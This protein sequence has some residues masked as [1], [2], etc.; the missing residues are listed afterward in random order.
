MKEFS[1]EVVEKIDLYLTGKLDAVDQSG[2]ETLIA[3]DSNLKEEV[4]F[5]KDMIDSIKKKE[6]LR[7]KSNLN[8]I[9]VSLTSKFLQTKWL[10]SY[11]LAGAIAIGTYAGVEYYNNDDNPKLTA[12]N[13]ELNT[14]HVN[15]YSDG[16]TNTE[17]VE[18]NNSENVV[19]NESTDSETEVSSTKITIEDASPITIN[20]NDQEE[21]FDKGDVEVGSNPVVTNVTK[22]SN[23]DVKINTTRGKK[24]EYQ[25]YEDKLYLYGNFTT[26]DPYVIY[27]I[28]TNYGTEYYFKIAKKYYKLE[29]NQ[30]EKKELNPIENLELIKELDKK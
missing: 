17:P 30:V 2:F 14:N 18:V 28:P 25:F 9:E 1:Q 22:A 19:S 6:I 8:S 5:Q 12:S 16:E 15:Y 3:S 21:N 23:V 7:I 4:N 20:D 29:P 13:V 26:S 27:D 11:A 24:V 10:V